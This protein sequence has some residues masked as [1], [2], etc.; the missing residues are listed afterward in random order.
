MPLIYGLTFLAWLLTAY[1]LSHI[2][3]YAMA[4]TV[5]QGLQTGIWIW[6]GFMV[7]YEVIHGLFESRDFRLYF[8][9]SGYHLV[10]LLI[11]GSMLA[12][13]T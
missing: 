3:D 13:W 5:F 9:N 1:V 2:V 12:V 4:T 10:A 6:L 8:I 11:M 7:T